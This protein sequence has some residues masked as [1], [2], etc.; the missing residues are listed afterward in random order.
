MEFCI[1]EKGDVEKIARNRFVAP[2]PA[3]RHVSPDRHL[4]PRTRQDGTPEAKNAKKISADG[5]LRISPFSPS[6]KNLASDSHR[7]PRKQPTA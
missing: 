2:T 3:A 5:S 6:K 4:L 1:F 7:R